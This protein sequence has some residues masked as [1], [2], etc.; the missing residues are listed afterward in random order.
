MAPDMNV[1]FLSSK[2]AIVGAAA[3]GKDLLRKRFQ[4]R[5]FTYGISCTTRPPRDG[6][7]N[8]R[9]Y[10]FITDEQFQQFID[11]D[12][13]VE[14]QEFNGWKY[15]LTKSEWEK[16]D[17]MILNAEAVDM[18]EEEYRSRLFVFYIDIPEAIRRERLIARND[19]DDSI[20][21]RILADDEQFGNFSN[22]DCKIIN[23]KF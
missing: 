1:G 6:E 10:Y 19:K 4:D 20:D 9:D 18:L 13:M 16:C 14:W 5:G 23:D 22:F 3:S 21:R 12:Q 8:G 7:K 15:G 11:D 17:L 2:I